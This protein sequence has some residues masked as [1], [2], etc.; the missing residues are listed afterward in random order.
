VR[1]FL[2]P[3]WL[4]GSVVILLAYP[5]VSAQNSSPPIQIL[6]LGVRDGHGLF[7]GNI[8]PEQV[9]VEGFPAT[10]VSLELDNAPRH[11][12]L[13]LD[14]SGIMGEPKTMSWSNVKQFATRF[15][16]QRQGEDSIGLDVYAEKNEVLSPF[17]RDSQSLI[18]QIET[19]SG[20]G[21][22]RKMFGRALT[23]ILSR[24][25]N[26]L[27][28]GDVIVLV[29][30]GERSDADKSDFTQIRD[31]LFRAGIRICLVRVP[32]VLERGS[33]KEVT[34]ISNF[35]KETG[36][37]ELNM[38]SPMQNLELGNGVRLDPDK[39]ASTAKAAY[40][41]SRAYYRLSLKILQ[42]SLKSQKLHL[43]LV[44]QRKDKMKGLRLN[45]PGHI[46][47]SP[48]S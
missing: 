12:L 30:S 33:L 43:E 36:G 22:G 1:H 40:E 3:R 13:L 38:A 48:A 34:D 28:F 4:L 45:Y 20:S 32:S 5:W 18:S 29:S 15:T 27:R 6:T 23:E 35:V 26:G 2:Y 25:E 41:F 39:V 37:I 11:I 42:P 46:L 21:K 7:V 16:L 9:V 24:R 19:Y 17:T 47:T 8:R 44:G 31:D 14:A 10:I